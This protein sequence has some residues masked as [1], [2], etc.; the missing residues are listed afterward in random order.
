MC[1]RTTCGATARSAPSGCRCRSW[2]S[3]GRGGPEEGE[4]V[5]LAVQVVHRRVLR[6]FA[7]DDAVVAGA[8]EPLVD[9]SFA[10]WVVDVMRDL[11]GGEARALP[12]R[13]VEEDDR[14]RLTEVDR[15][16]EPCRVIG[17]VDERG[18]RQ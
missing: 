1:Q 10:V 16:L 12:G 6:G 8:P 18:H 4:H 11:P 5:F 14:P 17:L 9:L 3:S 15:P 13:L 2:S 7:D